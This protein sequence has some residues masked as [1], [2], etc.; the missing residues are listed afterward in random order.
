MAADAARSC[1]LCLAAG[2]SPL[3]L[4]AC[5][6]LDRVEQLDPQAVARHHIYARIR[7]LDAPSAFLVAADVDDAVGLLFPQPV[8]VQAQ[9]RVQPPLG[10]RGQLDLDRDSVVAN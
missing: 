5:L 2:T 3:E 8:A 9:N 4:G 1:G 7:A 6:I 10:F